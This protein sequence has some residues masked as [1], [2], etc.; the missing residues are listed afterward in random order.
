MTAVFDTAASAALQHPLK[1]RRHWLPAGRDCVADAHLLGGGWLGASPAATQLPMLAPAGVAVFDAWSGHLKPGPSRQHGC[2]RYTTDGHWLHGCAEIADDGV[3]GLQASARK[4][5]AELFEVLATHECPH[6]LR[7]W[8][9]FPGMN[10]E[11][12]GLERYRQFNIGR[13]QAFVDARRSASEGAPAACAL[14]TREGPLRVFFLAGRQP[15]VAVE[16]P[17]QVSAYRYPQAYGPKAPTFSRAALADAGGGRTAL[18]ISGTAS[19]VGHQSMHL[20]DV[21]RQ[22]EESLANIDAVLQVAAATAGRPFPADRLTYTAY[23]RRPEDLDTVRQVVERTLGPGSE[24]AREAVYLQADVCR[25]DLLVEIEA[26]GFSPFG[27]P[28]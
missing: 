4:A 2:V 24:A 10:L 14:G 26:H 5:Y 18:F 23:L 6:L 22:T 12:Q 13:Q 9:Y 3:L 27:S 11:T 20:G 15:P 17:R 19:I 21:R 7:L 28:L 25:A 1:F 16:N 8:N